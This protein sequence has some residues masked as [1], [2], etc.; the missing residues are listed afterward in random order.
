MLSRKAYAEST[1]EFVLGGGVRYAN[2]L[3][4]RNV[5]VPGFGERVSDATGLSLVVSACGAHV[6]VWAKYPLPDACGVVRD[7]TGLGVCCYAALLPT[8]L[9][10]KAVQTTLTSFTAAKQIGREIVKHAT[11]GKVYGIR[12]VGYSPKS[13]QHC[14]VTYYDATT[15]NDGEVKFWSNETTLP[16]LSEGERIMDLDVSRDGTVLVAACLTKWDDFEPHIKRASCLRVY[17]ISEWKAPILL[18]TYDWPCEILA[19]SPDNTTVA[20]IGR[21]GLD[22]VLTIADMDL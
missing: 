6:G 18:R 14:V 15:G 9:T 20:M 11:D 3:Q 22:Q 17:A 21:R 4:V 5:T 10:T 7:E 8:F 19:L 12:C 2:G 1:P 16:A 13:A